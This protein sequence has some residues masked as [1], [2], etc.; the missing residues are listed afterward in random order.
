VNRR[1][2]VAPGVAPAVGLL[3]GGLLARQ[4]HG[5]RRSHLFVTRVRRQVGVP[6]GHR[7]GR[8]THPDLQPVF[9]PSLRTSSNAAYR[10][11]GFVVRA[12][13]SV[14]G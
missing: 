2:T 11:E 4:G 1:G 3:S 9:H 8:V 12:R 10:M 5:E 7:D 13:A 14:A 6:L